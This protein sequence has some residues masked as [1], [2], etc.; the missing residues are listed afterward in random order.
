M[1]LSLGFVLLLAAT[2]AE[3][4]VVNQ[5]QA[6]GRWLRQIFEVQTD[7]NRV[8]VLLTDAETGQRGYLLTGRDH[9]L[10]PYEAAR[11]QVEPALNKLAA[12]FSGNARAAPAL[13]D[14]RRLSRAKL[15]ELARTVE[16]RR[17]GHAAAALEI[18]NTDLGEHLM[19]D[20]RRALTSLGTTELSTIRVRS[21]DYQALTGLSQLVLLV[22]PALVVFLAGLIFVQGRRQVRE[23]QTANDSLVTEVEHRRIVEGQ[24]VQSQKMDAIGQLTGGI[25]HDFNNMLSVIV[26]SLELA[27][28]RFGDQGDARGLQYLDNAA[29]G[30]ER[31]A[32]LTSR[33]LAFARRQPL[34]PVVVDANRLVSGLSQMFQRTLGE[35]IH[36]E[37]VLGGGI[38][39]IKADIAQLESA[40]LNLV[41]NARDAMPS[42]GKLTI[43]TANANLDANYAATRPG[44]APGDYVMLSVSDDGVGMD[45]ETARNAFEPFFTTKETG[46][47]TGLGLSQVFGFVKQSEGHIALYSEPGKGTAVKLYMPRYIGPETVQDAALTPEHIPLGSRQ[48][49]ILVV[50][51]DAS[52]RRTTVDTLRD[53]GYSVVHA[54]GGAEALRQLDQHPTAILLVTDIVMPRMNGRELADEAL[55]RRPGLNVLFV[56]GYTRN[57]VVHQGVV[58]PGV[59]LLTKPFTLRQLAQR[60]RDVLDQS[61]QDPPQGRVV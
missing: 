29:V 47:G 23:L 14:L 2:A 48:E 37:M 49:L 3:L 33:L 57:A 26:G 38:W 4:V 25:A 44:A 45:E 10:A 34:D 52:V 15:D 59:A 19:T 58:D 24:L 30:A 5:Q 11:S 51:D 39:P 41:V 36:V 54:D 43:E 53:L 55:R 60:V 9:Y 16:L 46:K 13:A 21:R 61:P 42:G 12:D 56:T 50:E 1:L 6:A 18:V 35:T 32:M 40:L 20:V 22:T 7:L 28:R 27:R 8:R 17:A 31:A